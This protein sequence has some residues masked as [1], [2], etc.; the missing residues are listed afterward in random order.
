[1]I[2]YCFKR[3]QEN[4]PPENYPRPPKK[5]KLPPENCPLWIFPPMKARPYENYPQKFVPEKISPWENYPQWNPLPTYKSYKWKKQQN[6]KVFCLEESCAIQHP[7][8]MG[9]DTF[10]TEWK[11][12]KNQTKAK[13]AKWHLLASC[14]SQGELKLGSQ[15]IK[16]GKYVKLLNSQLSMHITLWILKKAN[17]KMHASGRSVAIVYE[18]GCV[19][20]ILYKYAWYRRIWRRLLYFHG[21]LCVIL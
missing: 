20:W 1:M 17:S 16:F 19:Y 13:I 6:C 12:S 18:C 3:Y 2:T 21:F 5:K 11:K 10:F 9:L 7:C 15:I 4:C 14:K 8:I